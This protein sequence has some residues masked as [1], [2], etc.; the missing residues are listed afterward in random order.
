LYPSVYVCVC[1]CACIC[2]CACM[3]VCALSHAH[4]MFAILTDIRQCPL[5]FL[6]IL[7]AQIL[8]TT[9]FYILQ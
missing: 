2:V 9:Y 8:N 3:C 7:F 1:V 4:T 5:W 6:F